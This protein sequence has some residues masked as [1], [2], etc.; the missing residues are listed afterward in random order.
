[1]D[2]DSVKFSVRKCVKI[3]SY[4]FLEWLELYIKGLK[5]FK[6]VIFEIIIKKISQKWEN[7]KKVGPLGRDLNF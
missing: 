6:N 5:Y 2:F 1:M 3:I 7:N 4:L